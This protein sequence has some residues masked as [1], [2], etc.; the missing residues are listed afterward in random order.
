MKGKSTMNNNISLGFG[1]NTDYELK[2]DSSIIEKAIIEMKIYKK[3]IK[4]K[5]LLSTERDIMISLLYFLSEEIGGECTLED[6]SVL[7]SFAERFEFKI[8]IGG[9][10]PRAAIA[11][12][13]LDYKSYLHLVV[14]NN[15]IEKLIPENC[16]YI[17]TNQN[18]NFDIHL[19][20]QYPNDSQILANDIQIRTKRANRIIIGN[21]NA[22][23][24]MTISDDFFNKYVTKSNVLMISGFNTMVDINKLSERLVY[25]K[26]KI[27]NL[28]KNGIKIYFEDACY[29]SD[30]ASKL[31]KSILFDC[32]DI[33]SFNEDEMQDYY[34]ESLNL[35]D[36]KK[37]YKVLDV[38]YNRFEVPTIVVHSKY[39][40]IAYGNNNKKYRE[41][42]KGGITMA[43]SRFRYGD[44]FKTKDQYM[45]TYNLPDEKESS[46]FSDDFNLLVGDKGC[47]VPSVEVKETDVTTIGL[48]DSFVGGFLP[49]LSQL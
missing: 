28:D 48:G 19:I 12:N 30:I 47:C 38:L 14:M 34:G 44:D 26:N 42:L 18:E 20:F 1:N 16:N 39:W 37:V 25:I 43:T 21:N 35:L 6:T 33:F 10:C 5:H 41:C 40:A 36:H 13:I 8:T 9:T 7:Q 4:K 23:S 2:W 27:N 32:I 3:D 22:N 49:P 29:I 15:F 31:T 24:V 45:D 46:K 17:T 11:M